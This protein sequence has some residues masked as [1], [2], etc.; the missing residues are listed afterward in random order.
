MTVGV[1]RPVAAA[2]PSALSPLSTTL[3]GTTR[4]PG[5]ITRRTGPAL[6][7]DAL[8]PLSEGRGKG[9]EGGEAEVLLSA[10]DGAD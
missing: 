5:P 4:G 1:S 7:F 10:G 9:G 3:S 2:R 8:D 6:A